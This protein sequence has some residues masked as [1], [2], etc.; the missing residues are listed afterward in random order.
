[1]TVDVC[2]QCD[3]HDVWPFLPL[4]DSEWKEMQRKVDACCLRIWTQPFRKWV[5]PKKVCGITDGADLKVMVY[6][7]MF[8]GDLM[9]LQKS[10]N[11]V[12]GRLP[13]LRLKPEEYCNLGEK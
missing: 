12:K 10:L 7:H 3:M 1:M 13:H 8:L 6:L 4:A 2:Y 11:V 5:V 9:D